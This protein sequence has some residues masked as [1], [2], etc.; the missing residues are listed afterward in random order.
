MAQRSGLVELPK[1][2]Q[3]SLSNMGSSVVGTK[4][5]TVKRSASEKQVDDFATEQRRAAGMNATSQQLQYAS[6]G[7]TVG[8]QLLKHAA[9][10]TIVVGTVI[11]VILPALAAAALIGAVILK[12]KAGH[13]KLNAFLKLNT[14]QFSDL[15]DFFKLAEMITLKMQEIDTQLKNFNFK[16]EMVNAHA[17]MYRLELLSISPPSVIEK[18]HEL[19][20]VHNKSEDDV[21]YTKKIQQKIEKNKS[22]VKR[23]AGTLERVFFSGLLMDNISKY[24]NNLVLACQ[25]MKDR[26][27]LFIN[28]YRKVFDQAMKDIQVNN[29]ELFDKVFSIP[30]GT[31]V[32]IS[33]GYGDLDK[34]VD[35]AI[36]KAAELAAAPTLQDADLAGTNLNKPPAPASSTGGWRRTRRHR[37]KS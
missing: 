29:K 19:S 5:A 28:I 27:F 17:S 11:P 22:W 20:K 6:I 36:A 24:Y 31:T 15:I 16:C 23:T 9:G 14:E 26:F 25:A 32:T 37:K 12:L 10:A 18:L 13:I 21:E 35:D 2:V 7:L 4:R 8:N 33:T 34:E 1:L 30:V 3:N